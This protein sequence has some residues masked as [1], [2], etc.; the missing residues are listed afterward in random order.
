MTVAGICPAAT[1]LELE[2]AKNN[3]H[4]PVVVFAV[5]EQCFKMECALI[6][7]PVQVLMML[8]P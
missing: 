2:D 5:M 1:S 7:A 6:Q 8:N 3:L 4:V